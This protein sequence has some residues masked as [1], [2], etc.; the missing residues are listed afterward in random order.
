MTVIWPTAR[1]Q[2]AQA[3]FKEEIYNRPLV[4]MQTQRT[5]FL[6]ALILGLAERAPDVEA[7][8]TWNARHFRDKTRL[9]VLAL[10]EFMEQYSRPV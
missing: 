3:F 2:T 1:A 9:H 10:S 5:A 7:F 4:K 8:V 6:D